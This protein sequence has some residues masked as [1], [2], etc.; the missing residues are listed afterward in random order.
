ME[1]PSIALFGEQSRERIDAYEETSGATGTLG[2]ETPQEVVLVPR[3]L[4][5]LRRLN[6]GLPGE[7]PRPHVDQLTRDSRVPSPEKA[8][9]EVHEPLK[10]GADVKARHADSTATPEKVRF[11]NGNDPKGSDCLL[12]SQL[13]VTGVLNRKRADIV[14][15]VNGNPLVLIELGASHKRLE[16]AR[17]NNLRDYRSATPSSS[18]ST[19]SSSCRT[20]VKIGLARRRP[21]GNTSQPGRRSTTRARRA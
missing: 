19:R 1:K 14:E 6:P 20:A 17:K 11:V 21:R 10:G 2:R 15:F 5:A 9:R 18:G 8:N 4:A 12:V 13:W 7:A 3:C 16:D